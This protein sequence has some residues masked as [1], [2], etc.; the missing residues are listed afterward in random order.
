[1]IYGLYINSLKIFDT[2]PISTMLYMYLD[3]ILTANCW[4][5]N[6]LIEA[7]PHAT[8][9]KIMPLMR[10]IWSNCQVE[11]LAHGN[12]DQAEAV[13]LAS[14]VS[15]LLNSNSQLK[16]YFSS[17]HL[18]Y[19]KNRDIHLPGTCEYALTNA[20]HENHGF[21]VHYQM[22]ILN[23]QQQA[24]LELMHQ[25]ISEPYF[26]QIRMSEQLAYVTFVSPKFTACGSVGL[27]IL[28][29]SAYELKYIESRVDAFLNSLEDHLKKMPLEVFNKERD[30]LI[31]HI[32][33]KPKQMFSLSWILWKEILL[34]QYVFNRNTK[35]VA[36]LKRFKP[37]DILELY[38][39]T[40]RP[41]SPGC[42]RLLITIKSAKTKEMKGKLHFEAAFKH[43]EEQSPSKET[44]S[45]R[46]NS[47]SQETK[48]FSSSTKSEY[49]VRLAMFL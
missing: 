32:S 4:T 10:S 23:L 26:N 22:G 1:M 38:R 24:L 18:L 6:E 39:S 9:D 49:K 46:S 7:F 15:Q 44:N 11:V 31:T 2:W 21:L 17:L 19:D 16:P 42:R 25:I 41:D 29:Q 28:I 5:F 3:N 20:F 12:I 30:A 47:P 14:K 36:Y 48:N 37:S 13:Q 34:S 40:L 27:D 33:E 43:A 45:F 8:D 35:L